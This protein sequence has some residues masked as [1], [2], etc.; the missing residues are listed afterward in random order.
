MAATIDEIAR[1]TEVA[2][3]RTQRTSTNARSG[4]DQV[5]KTIRHIESLAHR[6]TDSTQAAQALAHS[7]ATIGSVLDVIRTIAQQT[8]LLA[9]NAAIEAARA[10]EQGRGFAVVAGEIRTLAMRTQTATDEV[11]D[12]IKTLQEKTDAIVRLIEICHGE[13]LESAAQANQAGELLA[14]IAEDVTYMLDMNTQIA[15]AIEEQSRVATEVNR[16]VVV[17]RD[18]AE[19]AAAASHSNAQTSTQVAQQS[20]ALAQVIRR[21]RC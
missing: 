10:G 1:N 8:N 20:D 7:S 13:G 12:I 16:N 19:Q 11:G 2:A 17:I 4:H 21:F 18:V 9:L 5:Q 3:D 6:L 14:R 15:T